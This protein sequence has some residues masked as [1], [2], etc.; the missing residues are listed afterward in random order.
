MASLLKTLAIA[1]GAGVAFGICTTAGSRR[2]SRGYQSRPVRNVDVL[3]IEPLLDRLE[4]IERRLEDE[5]AKPAAVHAADLATRLSAQD[6]EIERLRALVDIRA[7]EIE[8][9]LEAE[10]DN[11]H[12]HALSTIEKTV[13]LKVAERIALIERTLLEQSASID[14]L[15]ERARDTDANLKRLI[16][17]IETLCERTQPLAAATPPVP[18]PGPVVVAFEK[19]LAEAQLKQEEPVPEFRSKI[20]LEPDAPKRPRFPLA[21]IFGM[22]A[23]V[24]LTSIL[25]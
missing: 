17:A 4:T 18:V 24:A 20:F 2:A 22:I 7:V 19:H 16:T 10:I 25:R 14:T 12:A 1:A 23:L 3:E 8:Q 6:T 9:R 5:A 15:R 11:R 13:E 21:R